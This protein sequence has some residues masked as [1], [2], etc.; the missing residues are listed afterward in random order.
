MTTGYEYVLTA[1]GKELSSV[2]LTLHGWGKKNLYG[3]ACAGVSFVHKT[4]GHELEPALACGHC[5]D[6]IERRDLEMRFLEGAPPVSE[7]L[8]KEE[9]A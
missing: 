7:I 6:K 9:A 2:L 5:G 3:E 4:C 8:A 1:A